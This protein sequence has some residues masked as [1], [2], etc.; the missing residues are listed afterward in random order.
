LSKADLGG[1]KGSMIIMHPLPRV[2]EIDSDV[3]DTAH[4]LYFEQAANG[5]VTRMALLCR[6]LDADIPDEVTA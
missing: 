6:M 4:A 2:D 1:A 3:D 5:V